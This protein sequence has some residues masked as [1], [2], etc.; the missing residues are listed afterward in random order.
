MIV[1]V[2]LLWRPQILQ[3]DIDPHESIY[4]LKEMFCRL[5]NHSELTW[6]KHITPKSIKMSFQGVILRDDQILVDCQLSEKSR[7][8][9]SRF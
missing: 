3:V 5:Y 2:K 8:M 6:S 7:V 4:T 1:V 9:A